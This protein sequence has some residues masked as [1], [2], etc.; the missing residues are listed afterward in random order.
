MLPWSHVGTKD[1][2]TPSC[3][4]VRNHS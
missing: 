1:Y 2:F 4:G 3:I